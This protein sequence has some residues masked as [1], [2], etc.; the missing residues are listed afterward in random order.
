[1]HI[2]TVC[3][4]HYNSDNNLPI[5]VIKLHKTA[6]S[7]IATDSSDVLILIHITDT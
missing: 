5:V 3:N 1:M 6:F 7:N 2:I 4:L